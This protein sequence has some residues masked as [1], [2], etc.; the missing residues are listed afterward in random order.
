M[1]SVLQA[2]VCV[3]SNQLDYDEEVMYKSTQYLYDYVRQS[4]SSKRP[5]CLT[6]SLTHPHDPYAISQEYWDRYEDVEIPMPR[7]DIPQEEQDPHSIRLLKAVDLWKTHI[8]DEAVKRARRAY[9]GACS[10]V[11]D[12][13][14]RLLTVLKNCQLDQNTVVVFGGDHGDML[15]ERGMWYK[16]SFLEM[17]ARVPMVFHCPQRFSAKR[18]PQPVSTL[19]LLPTFV[20]LIGGRLDPRLP[21]DGRSLYPALHG[22]QDTGATV[23]GE[24]MGEGTASPLMMI[25]RRQYKYITSLVDPPQLFNLSADPEEMNNLC[26]STDQ[27]DQML[28]T[29]FAVEACQKWNLEKIHSETLA[30]QRTRRLCWEA[31]QKGTFESWDYEPKQL[32]S[33]K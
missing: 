6:V 2:G 10:Y 23:Y 5:F 24:Y 22:E 14:G 32:A 3:R 19:D 12:Q 18:V 16:M 26:E 30:S 17:S 8:P 1:S 4:P 33:Q 20:D 25:R 11:D 9:Y 28:A 13:V 29:K 15:G 31:L 27:H 7:V 21:M